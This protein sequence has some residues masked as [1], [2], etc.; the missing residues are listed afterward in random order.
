MERGGAWWSGEGLG[1][2]GKFIIFSLT[3]VADDFSRYQLAGLVKRSRVS[4]KLECVRRV[5]KSGEAAVAVGDVTKV[6]HVETNR[7]VSSDHT[8]YILVKGSDLESSLA[9]NGNSVVMVTGN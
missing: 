5:L 8:H 7:V 4:E 2:A 6:R 9:D 3:Q 1:G